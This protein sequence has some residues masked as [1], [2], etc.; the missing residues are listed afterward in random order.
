[1]LVACPWRRLPLTVC[2]LRQEYAVEF[3]LHRQP[4]V[5]MP[6]A[7]GPVEVTDVRWKMKMKKKKRSEEAK[8]GGSPGRE[9]GEGTEEEEEEEEEEEGMSSQASLPPC[10]MCQQV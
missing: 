9:T 10:Y 3:P 8:S 5:H 4:P 7:Y 2:W 6:V 1:M